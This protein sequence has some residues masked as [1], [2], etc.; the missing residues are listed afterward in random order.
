MR[1]ET[2]KLAYTIP[3]A[4]KAVGVSKATIWRRV[5]AGELRTFK[6]CGRTLIRADVLQGALDRASGSEAA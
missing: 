6:W 1:E 2:T 3:E 5:S 4:A